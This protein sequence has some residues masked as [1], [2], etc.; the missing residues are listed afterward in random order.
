[1]IDVPE[2]NPA[3]SQNPDESVVAMVA[4]S[5]VPST[6]PSQP[7]AVEKSGW[8]DWLHQG[9]RAGFLSPVR[10]LPDGPGAWQMLLI[11]G[12]AVV[13]ITGASRLEVNGPASFD[14]RSWLFGWAS[15]AL[16]IVGVWLG[17]NWGRA[18][19]THAAPVAAWFLL[20]FV[21]IVPI[22]MVS[23]GLT[24]ATARKWLP[25]WWTGPTWLAW[26]I[27]IAFWIWIAGAAWRIT[28]AVNRSAWVAVGVVLYV[29]LVQGL[30]WSQL[31]TQAWHAVYTGDDQG[32]ED[33]ES[34][35]LQLSQEIFE[36]Q[37]ALL[38]KSLHAIK[39]HEGSQ[40]QVYGLIYAPYAQDV[41]LR[42]SAMVQE[43]LEQRFRAQG[44]TVRFV[45]HPATAAQ[46][47]WAT[48]RNLERGLQALARAMDTERDVLVLYLTS[49][50]GAD[51]TLAT[52]HWPLEVDTLTASRLREMLDKAGIRN[53]VVAVS[54]CYSGGWVEPLQGDNTLVMTAA[55]KDHT[56]YGC[57]SK[58][59]LTFFGRA[60]F[61]EQLR[62]TLSFED[63]FKAAVPIIKQREVEGE[64]S[65]GFSNPQISVG[66]DIRVVLHEWVEQW[67]AAH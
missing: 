22:S 2:E 55:D 1:M 42:E 15:T 9:L 32:D 50:G 53:R 67:P 48:N 5:D 54:A 51:F 47:P 61:D 38:D 41:F 28:R 19:A 39:S 45:N 60:I 44:H 64:K 40:R 25:N 23:L 29:L 18:K 12:L 66:K 43:V 58:S 17:L 36:T 62:K 59:E 56:S 24:V 37:Q 31:Q 7:A 13:L 57:G 34:D 49:H 46:F 6:E 52:Y 63:A 30:E 33:S 11:A 21:A 27:F 26:A 65:D 8:I 16:L 20:Y 35:T 4:A 10:Q 3:S 14:W